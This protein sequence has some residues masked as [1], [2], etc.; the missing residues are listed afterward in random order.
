MMKSPLTISPEPGTASSRPCRGRRRRRARLHVR[1]GRLSHHGHGVRADLCRVRDRPQRFHG[2]RRAGVVRDNA[3]AALSGY[4][5]AVLTTRYDF[6]PLPAFGVGLAFALIWRSWSATDVAVARPL[7]GDGDPRHRPHR[8]RGRGRVDRMTQGYMGISGIPPLGIAGLEVMSTA[9]SSRSSPRSRCWSV[10]RAAH[11][12]FAVRPGVD[13]R[14]RQRR[15]R[16][17]ARYLRGALQARR[18]LA[19]AAFAA[20]AGSLFV[21]VVGFVS[22]E[23]F[24]LH[25]VVLAFTMLYVGGIGTIAGPFVGAIIVSLLPETLRQLK[26]YQDLVYG[27]A[28]ILLLIYA[29]ERARVAG[30]SRAPHTGDGRHRGPRRDDAARASR[31]HEALRRPGRR[32]RRDRVGAGGGVT[33]VIGPNG[34]GKSTLF[35][36]ISGSARPTAGR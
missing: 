32:R 15:R 14:R 3:F 13:G 35:N 26:D 36:V 17:R 19:S 20:L 10:A 25:M 33:A 2:L 16:A 12:L 1:G 22:P 9:G 4:T 24:G 8:L 7:S 23:V 11:P 6:G 30:K 21:H 5:S 28:L 31:R 34:A 29:P 27:A 18:F